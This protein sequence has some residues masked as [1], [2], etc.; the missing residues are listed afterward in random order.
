MAVT[1]RFYQLRQDVSGKI[2][3]GTGGGCSRAGLVRSWGGLGS[4]ST[5]RGRAGGCEMY[6]TG[7]GAGGG[8]EGRCPTPLIP[9]ETTLAQSLQDELAEGAVLTCGWLHAQLL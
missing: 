8:A 1:S 5:R 9:L 2:E 6:A 4:V 7:G 3:A